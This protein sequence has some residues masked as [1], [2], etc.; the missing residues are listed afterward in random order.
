MKA[1]EY[2]KKIKELI[3]EENL[4]LPDFQ[5][6]FVWKPQEQ[7]L[8]LACSL[9]LDIP[10]GSILVL[11]KLEDTG[12]RK[13]CY[14]KERGDITQED[15]KLL[16]DGQQRISTIK[17]IFSNL[18]DS[19][20][21]WKDINKSLHSNLRH[22]WFLDLSFKDLFSNNEL[23]D[24]NLE[25]K[26]DFLYDFYWN[27]KFEGYD[28]EEI[29]PFIVNKKVKEKNKDDRWHPSQEIDKIENYCV[30]ENIL[31]LFMLLSDLS[32]FK[33]IIRR[34]CENY[35]EFLIKK[36]Q[37]NLI[38]KHIEDIKSNFNI[39]INNEESRNK[40]IDEIE[41]N[42]IEFFNNHIIHKEIYGVEYEKSQ[43]NKAIVAFNT[44]NTGGI[45]LGVFDI[46]SARYS[47]LKKGKLS[48]KLF[49]LAT[50]EKIETIDNSAVKELIKDKF[51]KDDKNTITKMFSDMYL[52]MLSIFIKKSTNEDIKL[53][54][55]KQKSPLKISAED[56]ERYSEEAIE[57][58][59]LAFQFLIKRCGTP[60]IKHIKSKFLVIPL[61]YNLY[62]YKNQKKKEIEDQIEYSYWMSLFSGKY[63]KVPQV[64]SIDH[65]NHLTRFIKQSS[66]NPFKKY[67]DDL[68]K[69]KDILI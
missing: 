8:K 5:R 29:K 51:I 20:R 37:E 34:I 25:R 30:E 31:P 3:L 39:A 55:I 21:E 49:E 56:I 66:D 23:S 38:K 28:I 48:D 17:S 68:C 22:R 40:I 53:D 57:S 50:K 58:L 4:L 43:L 44:M 59:L 16:M 24:N 32:S 54:W 65:L 41:T 1:K 7:Q 13:L 63:E 12:L 33:R 69:K 9:F 42:T 18:Y 46:V 64:F 19:T 26:L 52:N 62:E 10:I 36:Q 11:D 47:S 15:S 2:R 27:K 61:A 6:D 60:S 45:S 14:K 35:I 67:E